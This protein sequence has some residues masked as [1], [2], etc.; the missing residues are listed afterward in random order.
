[1]YIDQNNLQD[2]IPKYDPYKVRQEWTEAEKIQDQKYKEETEPRL[3]KYIKEHP[4]MDIIQVPKVLQ[5][6]GYEPTKLSWY[7]I[8][9]K[10]F[11][12]DNFIRDFHDKLNLVYVCEHQSVSEDIMREFQDEIGWDVIS[13]YQILSED[14]IEEFADKVN[15]RILSETQKDLSE[16]FLEKHK[17]K[18]YWPDLFSHRLLSEQFLRNHVEELTQSDSW[19]EI[20]LWHRLPEQFYRDYADKLNDDCWDVLADKDFLSEQF[21]IDYADKFKKEEKNMGKILILCDGDK[22]NT[23]QILNK[24]GVSVENISEVPANT[25]MEELQDAITENRSQAIENEDYEALEL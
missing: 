23:Q 3:R 17:D 1:M 18:W 7:D 8:S 12:S 11:L 6:F 14:F 20:C 13:K 21:F 10:Y 25:T 19:Y 22:Q 15:W 5:F 16:E 2:A 24:N 4:F 9:T